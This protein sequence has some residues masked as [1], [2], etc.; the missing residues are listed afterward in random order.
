M[1]SAKPKPESLDRLLS[2]VSFPEELPITAR[3]GEIV[4]AIRNHQVLV[5]SGETG[6]GKSTQIPKLCLEAGRGQ[7]GLI[8]CTQPRR[9]AAVSVADRV[10]SELGQ[11]TGQGVGYKIRFQ[12]ECGPDTIIKFLTDGMLL[13]EAHGDPRLAAYDTIIIDE[14]HERSLNIDFLIGL[15]RN[16][17]PQ[18]P[19]LKLIVTSA[20]IDTAKFSRAFNDAPVIEVSGRT[21][22][23][24]VFYRPPEEGEEELSWPERILPVFREV[25]EETRSGDILIFMPTE[26]DILETCEKIGGDAGRKRLEILPLYSRLPQSEQQKIFRSSENR[27]V[28]VATNIAETSL[29]IPGIR[30][31]IDTGVAR[32]LH[33]HPAS[34]TYGLPVEPVSRSSADQRK[35]RSGRV[36]NGLCYR[37]YS[38][39]DYLSRKEFT[40]PEIVRT[41]LA[42]VVLR[43]VDLGI[44]DIGGFPFI[45][46]PSK[47][48]IQDAVRTLE[49]LGALEPRHRKGRQLRLTRDGRLMARL[50]LD[51]RLSRVL[52][53][54]SRECCL[55]EILPIVAALTIQDP[56]EYSQEKLGS[57]REKHALFADPGS[58][59]LFYLNLW[60]LLD[61]NTSAKETK[62]ICKENY[63]SFRR[64]QEWRDIHGQLK[65]LVKGG[66]FATSD[67]DLTDREQRYTAIH[68]A[69]LTGFLS[70]IAIKGEGHEYRTTRNRNFFIFPGSVLFSKGPDWGFALEYVKTTRVYG[71]TMARIDPDWLPELGRHL[72]KKRHFNP[73]WDRKSGT[74]LIAEEQSLFGFV[75]KKGYE[76]PCG[77]VNPDLAADLF[78][79]SVFVEHDLEALKDFPF[80]EANRKLI[81][82]TEQLE[83]K[84][85]RRGFVA[86][87]DDL[88]ALFKTRLPPLFDLRMLTRHIR[89]HGDKDLY[90]TRDDL[91][92][93]DP[94]GDLALLYPDYFQSG[95][96]RVPLKYNFE[97]GRD[98]DGVSFRIKAEELADFP[99]DRLD[100][101]VPGL[102]TE[103]IEATLRGLP[104]EHRKKL[105]PIQAA[106]D[107]IRG[108]MLEMVRSPE[109]DT[110]AD[111]KGF[112]QV[113]HETV[114]ELY[115][116]RLDTTLL[117]DE[118]L[119]D[120]LKF[121]YEL[122]N[123][124]GEL[125]AGSRNRADLYQ[126]SP[127]PA[128][129]PG[130]WSAPVKKRFEQTG[131]RD[132][133]DN[134]PFGEIP[135]K[136]RKGEP[137]GTLYPALVDGNETV[138]LRLL[139]SRNEAL[140]AHP[141]GVAALCKI[142]FEKEI[143]SFRGQIRLNGPVR[144]ALNQFS[145]GGDFEK[146]LFDRIIGDILAGDVR[147]AAAYLSHRKERTPLVYPALEEQFRLADLVLES[148]VRER[149]EIEALIRSEPLRKVYLNTRLGELTVLL[150][151]RFF[152]LNPDDLSCWGRLPLILGGITSRARKGIQDPQKDRNREVQFLAFSEKYEGVMAD[153]PAWTPAEK[154]RELAVFGWKLLEW[155]TVLFSPEIRLKQP[156]S[157]SSLGKELSRLSESL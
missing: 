112:Y 88:F 117:N 110:P 26:Q 15:L 95:D 97:P 66:G 32:I 61:K 92:R 121:R 157:E 102:L 125:V 146:N 12:D 120:Y 24:E 39:E 45:D 57:A 135:V 132:W 5:L 11:P 53:Q 152:A 113:L 36:E 111:G 115:G 131:L 74:V 48:G 154:K 38:E 42:E 85:R 82:D 10:A 94:G 133:P 127:G 3:R 99:F 103:K 54:G 19:D 79:R 76:V 73:R 44:E 23:V 69:L 13:S 119:P 46:P 98:A 139:S 7:K 17:L 75:I 78:I 151:T 122:Y 87:P 116:I 109:M 147:T 72:L 20:T 6:S 118:N 70:H 155:K 51:P 91:L 101:A 129:L 124:K 93:N 33:Y 28:I 18:R 123:R 156:V 16:L 4:D 145:E 149:R 107:N 29:T 68:R 25:A 150:T 130:E 104:K 80:L 134:F 141:A 96:T 144:L 47:Q 34:G 59:F 137:A 56:R 27:K 52:L 136:N 105:I 50:P 83:N 9:I 86:D 153:I 84:L 14:A 1:K 35:G 22:P 30:Y 62:R 142:W 126:K 63:L 49:E 100:W 37:L 67:Q 41:N 90:L 64:V 43:M 89:E 60:T 40:L 128:E 114:R 31:V 148:Y 81:H 65:K 140:A 8:A 71:R 2:A 138:S 55:K 58:D 106:V 77:P 21:W 108:R 143:K